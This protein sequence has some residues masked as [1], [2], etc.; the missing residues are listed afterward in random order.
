MTRIPTSLSLWS[1]LFDELWALMMRDLGEDTNERG[2]MEKRQTPGRAG[3]RF[4]APD[5]PE[6]PPRCPLEPPCIRKAF[7]FTIISS[8]RIVCVMGGEAAQR[9]A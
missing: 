6:L 3:H 1:L 7:D 2:G 4:L 8:P 9:D 5:W